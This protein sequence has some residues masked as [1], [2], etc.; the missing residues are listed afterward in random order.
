M[1]VACVFCSET[2][3]LGASLRAET[4][5][6][7]ISR[8]SSWMVSSLEFFSSEFR[9]LLQCFFF[10]PPDGSARRRISSVDV[11]GIGAQELLTH[12]AA[13]LQEERWGRGHFE[14]T[15]FNDSPN[16]RVSMV[17][18]FVGLDI[19]PSKHHKQVFRATGEN[20]LKVCGG[21]ALIRGSLLSGEPAM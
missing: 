16:S 10:S 2:E 11:A 19:M 14:R 15:R 8:A 13:S 6:G 18:P 3:L 5:P 17:P 12:R 9:V 7:L 1:A 20:S 21:C 4:S